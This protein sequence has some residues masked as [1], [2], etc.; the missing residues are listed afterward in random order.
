MK[1]A[2]GNYIVSTVAF[3]THTL[4]VNNGTITDDA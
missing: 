2:L 1:K 3:A 4:L